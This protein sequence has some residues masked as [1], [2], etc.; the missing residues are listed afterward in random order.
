MTTI[1]ERDK[2]DDKTLLMKI[3]PPM[4]DECKDKRCPRT[5]KVQQRCAA[6]QKPK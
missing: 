3:T 4:C 6:N 5:L 2:H 1:I